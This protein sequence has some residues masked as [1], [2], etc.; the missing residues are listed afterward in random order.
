MNELLNS[1]EETEQPAEP[2]PT[3]PTEPAPAEPVPAELYRVQVGV[4]A[5]RE[6]AE[7]MLQ[8]LKD[9]GFEGFIRQG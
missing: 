2:T 9:A 3:E 4:F 7:R 5:N 8:R 6:N 1:K